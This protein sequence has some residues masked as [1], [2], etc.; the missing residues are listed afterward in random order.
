MP[1]TRLQVYMHIPEKRRRIWAA[2]GSRPADNLVFLSFSF[3]PDLN[4][5]RE[6]LEEQDLGEL[7]SALA[8]LLG[9]LLGLPG[10]DLDKLS[11]Q[12]LNLPK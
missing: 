12:S 1:K 7:E 10:G 9:G 8:D 5:L 2:A 6:Q 4:V 3:D 11:D